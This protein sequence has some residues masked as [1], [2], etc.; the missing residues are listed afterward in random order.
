MLQDERLTRE[1]VRQMRDAQPENR[2]E[3][4]KLQIVADGVSV[5]LREHLETCLVCKQG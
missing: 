2:A 1:A 3:I 5:K 4:T